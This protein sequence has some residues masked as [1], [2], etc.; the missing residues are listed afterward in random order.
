MILV[1]VL[2]KLPKMTHRE[3]V[4]NGYTIAHKLFSSLI[5]ELSVLIIKACRHFDEL[6]IL[7]LLR[8]FRQAQRA[9]QVTEPVEVWRNKI[10][11]RSFTQRV[12]MPQTTFINHFLIN[13]SQA[14]L[15]VLEWND[16]IYI[17]MKEVYC[18]H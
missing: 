4:Q 15:R 17:I 1:I 11:N 5:I 12:N 10:E 9:M 7:T 3:A 13:R 14:V 2:Q 18:L 8:A 16:E 6:I